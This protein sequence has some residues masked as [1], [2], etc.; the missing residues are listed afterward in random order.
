[1]AAGAVPL[2]SGQAAEKLRFLM[3][4]CES[5]DSDAQDPM[6]WGKW[7]GGHGMPCPYD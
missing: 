1:M 5:S 7:Q 3:S 6:Q 2:I 4:L